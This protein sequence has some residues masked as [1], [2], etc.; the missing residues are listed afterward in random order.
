MKKTIPLFLIATFLFAACESDQ[1]KNNRIA[2]EEQ[3]RVELAQKQRAD[4]LEDAQ[5]REAEA[6]LQAE[7]DK[8]RQIKQAAELEKQRAEQAIYDKFIHNSLRNGATPYAYCYGG[9][10]QCDDFGCSKISV[11]TPYNSDV[12]VMIKKNDKVIRHAYI[13][14]GNTYTF[15]MTNGTYQPF[16]YY[17]KGW[18]PEKIMKEAPC[19]KLKGGFIADE[20]FGK[21]TPQALNNN[22][23]Q[24][25]LVL[26]ENGN[27]STKPSNRDEAL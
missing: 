18:N 27:F 11:K 4:S 17:G 26:Q 23:L 10:K 19:G 24:Y 15:E 14:A 9:N 5:K 7:Q 13:S 3:Q 1:E 25:E 20:D 6:L 22:E 12:L 2:K 16:F 8:E 21:D